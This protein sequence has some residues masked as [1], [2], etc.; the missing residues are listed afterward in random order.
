[1]ARTIATAGIVMLTC[2]PLLGMSEV[3]RR[4][5]VPPVVES[6]GNVQM[7]IEDAEH[8]SPDRRQAIIDAFP[9]H[10]REARARG[11][12][13]LGS[14]LI[15]PVERSA[16]EIAPFALPADWP[17]LCGLD[18]GW[19]H[20]TAAVWAAIDRQANTVYVY[21]CYRVA[22]QPVPIHA[23][24]IKARGGWIPVAWPHDGLQHDKGSG[25]QIASLY[26]AQGVKML[27]EHAT[28]P[29]GTNGV[30]AGLWQLLTRMETGRL[31]V[32]RH[33]RD[34]F[35]EFLTLHRKEGRVVKVGD[36]LISATRYGLMMLRYARTRPAVDG[37]GRGPQQS[38]GEYDPFA[39]AET[40]SAGRPY[41]PLSLES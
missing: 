11:I 41:D 32:F 36:D 20:P 17:R 33:L 4:F 30:E 31:R 38:A 23:S 39:Y 24:A 10:E 18:F 27:P 21:D 22:R 9:A 12:P 14:G 34:W 2:T 19:E 7:E 5:L 13:V 26:R 6:R 8:I 16:L 29:D 40:G 1:M 28:F 25:D 15:F 37:R 3:M 35:S